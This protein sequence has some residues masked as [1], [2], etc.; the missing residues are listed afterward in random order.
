MRE[1][2]GRGLRIWWR[3]LQTFRL[4]GRLL[5]II[6]A[7]TLLLDTERILT[8]NYG[9]IPLVMALLGCGGGVVSFALLWL[10]TRPTPP[11]PIIRSWLATPRWLRQWVLPI[12]VLFSACW[13]INQFIPVP[14]LGESARGFYRVDALAYAH[15]DGDLVL[16]GQNPYTAD[17][18]FWEAYLRW[19]QALSTPLMGP[20]FGTNPL[21]YP[22]SLPMNR[23]LQSQTAHPSTRGGAFDAATVHNYPAGLLWLEVPLLWAGLPSVVWLNLAAWL[24]ACGLVLA[25]AP[26]GTRWPLAIALA[27]S[28]VALR[29][30]LNNFDIL[31]LVFVLGAWHTM[32][33]PRRSALLMGFACAV[34]QTAWFFLPFYLLDVWQREGWPGLRTRV[35]WLAG[36]FVV[37]N[38]PFILLDPVAWAKSIWVPLT[39]P[40]FPFGSG[41][42]ALAFGGLVPIFTAHVWTALEVA[43]MGGL[44][45]FQA[46]RRSPLPDSLLLA[47]VPLWFAWR[48]PLNYF[49]WVPLFALYVL[50]AHLA[51]QRQAP[52]PAAPVPVT[53]PETAIPAFPTIAAIPTPSESVSV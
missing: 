1:M 46:W 8:P 22:H 33:Q 31:S 30:I 12:L 27:F 16:R 35:L 34:K 14:F 45:V 41:A 2:I 40:M 39:D 47:L 51:A 28:P 13:M 3:Q 50:A 18:A 49:A 44:L 36:G 6:L 15:L 53:P 9:H 5:A 38:L 52:P 32:A 43:V 42:I 10:A 21:T 26:A 23:V 24:V 48:S 25:R 29:N 19:P 7:S 4:D 20:I 37:P 11:R 17:D